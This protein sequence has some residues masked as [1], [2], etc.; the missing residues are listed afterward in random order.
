MFYSCLKVKVYRMVPQG[1]CMVL[2][3]TLQYPADLQ[4]H[5]RP[6]ARSP[7]SQP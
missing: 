7:Q 6:S 5:G 4:Q 1:D 3:I 2:I